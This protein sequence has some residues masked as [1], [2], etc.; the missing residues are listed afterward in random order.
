MIGF[1]GHED[2]VT[3]V[4]F[5]PDGENV[6]SGSF[7]GTIRLWDVESGT[8]IGIS[9]KIADW[10]RSV[11]FIGDGDKIVSG[12]HHGIVRIWDARL[13]AESKERIRGHSDWVFSVAISRDG[14]RVCSGSEDRTVRLW[15]ARTG[16][17]SG[18]H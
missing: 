3:S 8:C 9:P 2:C 7:D 14:T 13:Q 16:H 4:A 17:Q 18:H 5:S 1:K 12:S 11:S 15:D 6:A 10:V